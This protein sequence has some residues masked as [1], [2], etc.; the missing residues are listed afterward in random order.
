MDIISYSTI[1]DVNKM[2]VNV[3][4]FGRCV[5]RLLFRSK[6]RS[7][8]DLGLDRFLDEVDMYN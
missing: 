5:Q 2:F 1:G 7:V 4:I 8:R 6:F 3:D